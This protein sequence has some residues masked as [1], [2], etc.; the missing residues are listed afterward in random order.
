MK[1]KCLSLLL[2]LVML[3]SLSVPALAA[4][5]RETDFF[6]DQDHS[7]VNYADMEYVPVDTEAVLAA[8]DEVRALV[9]D[10]AN[11][12][13]VREGFLAA[14]DMNTNAKTMYTLAYLEW[15]KDVLNEEKINT[16]NEADE[17]RIDVV[18]GLYALARDILNSPCAAA[19]D[20]IV[21]NE[22]DREYL[23]TY[24]DF[25]EE[26]MAMRNEIDDLEAEYYTLAAVEYSAVVD[27]VEWT[28]ASAED[29]YY[30]DEIS[31]DDYIQITRA[32]AKEMNAVLGE[33]YLRII[34]A[35]KREAA[36][37]EYE[38]YAVYAYE[39]MGFSFVPEEVT[40]FHAA[41][42][43]YFAPLYDLAYSTYV[44][45]YYATM[46]DPECYAIVLGDY[47]GDIALD[48]LDPYIASLS[49]EMYE[50]FTYMREHGLYDSEYNPAKA[51]RGFT[52]N[53][54]AYGAPFFFN[55][56]SGDIS[57]LTTAVHEFGHYNNFYWTDGYWYNGS[58]SLD[59]AEVH[60]QALEL[61]FTEFYPE[62]FGEQVARFFTVFMMYNMIRSAIINGAMYDELQQF[63]FATEDVTLQQINEKY[64]QLCRE[65]GIID[66]DDERTEMYGWVEIPHTFVSPF[67]YISY[68]VSA[69]GAFEFW[70]A[71]QDDYF[72]AVDDYLRY[73]AQGLDEY[74]FQE[75]FEAVG[76]ESPFSTEFVAALAEE[77][78][79]ILS[80]YSTP[81]TADY[82]VDVNGDESWYDAVDF[83]YTYGVVN[84]VEEGVFAPEQAMTRAQASTVLCRL[85]GIEAEGADYF[86]D[87]TEGHWYTDMI[88]G[89]Y[90]WGLVQG[91]EDGTFRPDA[92]MSRQDFA[93]ILYNIGCMYG[94]GFEGMWAFD[95][96]AADADQ[97]ADY[98]L[99]AV[100]WCVMYEI[101]ELD[102]N[103][104]LRPA[105]D[106]TRAEM[107]E[108]VYALFG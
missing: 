92:T 95:L 93:Q 98:A 69:A 63:A 86:P 18:D 33:L 75:S 81:T 67:Y 61:L 38:D 27:G 31:Y 56:P 76:L 22:E 91:F 59:V 13:A 51:D 49:S 55:Q 29:A 78:T 5:T 24:E 36:L 83:L 34:D 57:D 10:E 71:A 89:A 96:G 70:L 100:S 77:L 97:I 40:E 73:V 12:D 2:A 28:D 53:I 16:Y 101:M 87:V 19:L 37:E 42:K 43:E 9:E 99:E 106:L 4:E 90:E 44:D 80:G 108:M 45:Q 58:V 26:E 107:A 11:I 85:F 30:A 14:C 8:M 88:N 68:A 74:D 54:I 46:Y 102:E 62:I 15:Q 72:A 103:S 66:E 60:S 21:T 6:T 25:T 104:C 23:M 105:D 82:F 65:Y 50:A 52:T 35:H 48:I 32:I 7:D 39:G 3:L 79:A 94:L 64:C 41:V 84:G 47:T 20:D 1:K 17:A